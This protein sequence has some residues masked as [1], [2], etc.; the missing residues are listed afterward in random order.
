MTKRLN[1]LRWAL[2]PIAL[3]LAAACGGS[4]GMSPFTPQAALK[5]GANARPGNILVDAESRSD[6]G[7]R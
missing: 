6:E 5:L 7:A 4:D 3:A 1:S 2:A